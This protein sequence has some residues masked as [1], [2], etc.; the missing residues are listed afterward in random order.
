MRPS[1]NTHTI[2]YGSRRKTPLPSLVVVAHAQGKCAIIVCACVCVHQT[3]ADQP[4]LNGPLRG[5]LCKCSS[6]IWRAF[7][8]L[9]EWRARARARTRAI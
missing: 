8:K 3:H 2:R 1:A 5:R 4:Y 9:N 6:V 7:D